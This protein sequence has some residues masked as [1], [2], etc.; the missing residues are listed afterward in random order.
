MFL[1]EKIIHSLAEPYVARAYGGASEEGQLLLDAGN[2]CGRYSPHLRKCADLQR[3]GQHLCQAG[4]S[5]GGY[6][7]AVLGSQHAA[8]A[9]VVKP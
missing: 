4:K 8:G 7:G 1:A 6:C 3:G 2:I 9:A 5:A